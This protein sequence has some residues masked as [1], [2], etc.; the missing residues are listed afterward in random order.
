MGECTDN[1]P[2]LRSHDSLHQG[3]PDSLCRRELRAFLSQGAFRLQPRRHIYLTDAND[4][5]AAVRFLHRRQPIAVVS[6]QLL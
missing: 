4:R 2:K 3:Q 1:R 5:A 6:L